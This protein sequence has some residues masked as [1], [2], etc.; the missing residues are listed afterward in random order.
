MRQT[1][2]SLPYLLQ[3]W[4]ASGIVNPASR[5][6]VWFH[7]RACSCLLACLL[8][9]SASPD[10]YVV[11]VCVMRRHAEV[12]AG[13]PCAGAAQGVPRHDEPEEQ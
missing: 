7:P 12:G 9:S 5:V 1:L 8:H 10:F 2:S 13:Q 4:I 11:H 3:A 6:C